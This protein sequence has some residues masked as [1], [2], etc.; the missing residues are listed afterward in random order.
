MIVARGVAYAK[1]RLG[2]ELAK[3]EIDTEIGLPKTNDTVLRKRLR[4]NRLVPPSTMREQLLISNVETYEQ[5]SGVTLFH[6]AR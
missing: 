1:E 3:A 2:N 5:I 4:Q 6:A